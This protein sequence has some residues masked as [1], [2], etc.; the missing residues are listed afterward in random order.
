[1]AILVLGGYVLCGLGFLFLISPKA[2]RYSFRLTLSL[3]CLMT[4]LGLPYMF[5]LDLTFSNNFLL[6]SAPAFIS[7][8]LFCL[9]FY[10]ML[11]SKPVAAGQL[12][13]SSLLLLSAIWGNF[14]TVYSAHYCA[15]G[16][17]A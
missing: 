14:I 9:H 4:A 2:K 11:R 15:F 10:G 13:F 8:I 3:A 6:A 16:A 12:I 1:M 17:C 5:L 7:L